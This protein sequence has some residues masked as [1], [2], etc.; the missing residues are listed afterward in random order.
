MPGLCGTVDKPSVWEGRGEGGEGGSCLLS[1]PP[2]PPSYS[3]QVAMRE[4]HIE[5]GGE[6]KF[7]HKGTST[8]VPDIH[9]YITL[10][11]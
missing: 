4:I 10:H 1:P 11:V 8:G 5:G 9:T 7:Q 2:L 3:A 6:G